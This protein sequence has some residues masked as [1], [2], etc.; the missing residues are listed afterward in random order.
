M[1]CI[2]GV[3]TEPST[4]RDG[5]SRVFIHGD[6]GTPSWWTKAAFPTVTATRS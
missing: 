3:F 4:R 5:F 1:A 6:W 2:Q